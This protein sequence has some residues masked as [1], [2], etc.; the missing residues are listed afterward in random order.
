MGISGRKGA[1]F[2]NICI[3]CPFK[4]HIMSIKSIKLKYLYFLPFLAIFTFSTLSCGSNKEGCPVNDDA[5]VKTNRSGE[6]P[7]GGGNSNLFSK[8]MRKKMK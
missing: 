4:R 3:L 7:T 2:C 5:H 6:L 8:K 1:F